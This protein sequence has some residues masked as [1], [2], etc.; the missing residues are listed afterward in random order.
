MSAYEN[1]GEVRIF[2]APD[3]TLY[4]HGDGGPRYGVTALASDQW[5]RGATR[6]TGPMLVA[7]PSRSILAGPGLISDAIMVRVAPGVSAPRRYQ[8][9]GARP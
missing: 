8:F 3:G 9:P 6:I 5:L 2:L 4:H 7:G 1:G